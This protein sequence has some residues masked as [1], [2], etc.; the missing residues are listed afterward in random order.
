MK[1]NL[2]KVGIAVGLIAGLTAC[3]SGPADDPNDQITDRDRDRSTIESRE[4]NFVTDAIEAN[5]ELAVWLRTAEKEATDPELKTTARQ[6]INDHEK[7]GMELKDYAN[8]R[9]FSTDDLDTTGT[10][11]IAESR[12]TEWDEEWADEIGDKH[13]QLIRKFERAQDRMEDAELKNIITQNLPAL[14][15]GLDK[16]EKQ[17]A[18]LDDNL[19]MATK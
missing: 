8:K 4:E 11:N 3:N 14:R 18:R 2:F 17:E 5:S 7:I 1:L 6:M 19:T 9:K 13:R 12:G 15:S 10:V 16:V